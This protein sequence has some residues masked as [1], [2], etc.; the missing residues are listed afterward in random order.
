MG[1]SSAA[2]FVFWVL[3][4][5]LYSR[6]QLGYATALLGA[7]AL[8]TSFSNLGLNRTIVRFLGSSKTQAQDIATK[9]ALIS[10]GSL[11]VGIIFS[12]LLHTFG[13]TH[14]TA[15]TSLVFVLAVIV[16]SAKAVY[17]NVF[18]ALQSASSNLIEN[19]VANVVKL[20]LPIF[21][22]AWGFEGIF[23]A[24]VLASLGGVICSAIVLKYRF[25]HKLLARPSR[26]SLTGRMRFMFGSYTTDLVGGLPA[27]ILPII[28]VS[29]L[30]AT[31]GA[32]WYSAMLLVNFLLLISSTISQAMFAEISNTASSI[33][34]HVK[35]ALLAMYG[36]VLPLTLLVIV[37]APHILA[38]FN[39]SYVQVTPILRLMAVFALIGVVN[40]AA[41][42]ILAYYKK[43][44][45]LTAA[46]I[47]NAGVVLAYTYFFATNLKG[48]AVGWAWGEVVNLALFVGGA[49]YYIRQQ[50]NGVR[51]AKE[52]QSA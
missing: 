41:G 45:Y 33:A 23:S 25:K 40:Y 36:L 32:L 28:V 49:I 44:A 9:L 37:Y 13:V 35:K 18:I 8:A 4:A 27:S 14:A 42:S 48:I 17:D 3:C 26:K 22:V 6:E 20:A 34:T 29:K 5:H 1:L 7:L 51:L 11:I 15:I 31:Q 2:G 12:L 10:G 39:R 46:N 19:A 16:T 52:S 30:G 50:H 47:A 21:V 43:V 38:I 24:Q